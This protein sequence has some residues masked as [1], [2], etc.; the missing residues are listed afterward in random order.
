M[1]SIYVLCRRLILF[2][3]ISLPFVHSAQAQCEKPTDLSVA[4]VTNVGATLQ[5]IDAGLTANYEIDIRSKGRTPKLKRSFN[6]TTTDFMV[7][8]LMLG[9]EYRFR[10][11]SICSS[12][13]SSGSTKWFNFQTTGM[14]SDESCPKASELQVVSATMT[15]ATLSWTGSVFSTHYEVEVRSKGSTPVYFFEKSLLDSAITVFGLDPTGHY[16]F[17]VRTTCINDAVSGSTAWHHFNSVKEIWS[18][19]VHL[20]PTFLPIPSHRIQQLYIGA[21]V[22]RIRSI[23]WCY[24]MEQVMILKSLQQH[25]HN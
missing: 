25:H 10:V 2:F 21:P 18:K 11:R 14:S 15:T 23:N 9:S 8:D 20:S 7:S 3:C 12:G 19:L 17:R 5:W 6:T 16:Q 24:L 13:A 22:I 4:D 1:R